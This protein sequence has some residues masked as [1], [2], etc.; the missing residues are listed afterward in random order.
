MTY[1]LTKKINEDM[2]GAICHNSGGS[3]DFWTEEAECPRRKDRDAVGAE[4]Q[5]GEGRRFPL[6]TMPLNGIFWFILVRYYKHKRPGI[7]G[8]KARFADVGIHSQFI[9]VRFSLIFLFFF[10]V[11]D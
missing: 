9:L 2:I 3:M 1:D 5:W 7:A 10:R 11:I 4:G 8:S 6:Q